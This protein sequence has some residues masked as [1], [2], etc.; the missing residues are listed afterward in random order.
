MDELELPTSRELVRKAE[1]RGTL[2]PLSAKALQVPSIMD[3]IEDALE[4]SYG[5]ESAGEVL[6]VT[7]MPD[8]SGSMAGR[9]A[10]SVRTGHNELLEAFLQSSSRNKILLQTR[11]LNTTL[12]NPFQPLGL[13]LQMKED[14]Y[15]CVFGTPL[16]SQTIVTLGTV[17]VKAEELR[18]QG[19]GRVRSATLIMTDGEADIGPEVASIVSDMRRVGDHIVAGMGFSENGRLFPNVFA[20][21]G[22]DDQFIFTA[23]SREE[24]LR[25]FRVF[26]TEALALT[27]G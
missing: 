21:M 4:E 10:E 6:L 7:L 9:K 17:L 2:S 14:N 26:T 27:R 5:I 8:D 24:I 15:P 3:Q 22:I 16:S 25:A 1:V 11:Y 20:A 13:C 18:A 12:L 19:A 23:S